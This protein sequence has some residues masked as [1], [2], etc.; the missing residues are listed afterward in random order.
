DG[1]ELAHSLFVVL[2]ARLPPTLTLISDAPDGSRANPLEPD[3]ETVG[4][5]AGP[6]GPVAIV[7]ERVNRPKAARL[8]LFSRETL[9][10]IGPLY[11]DIARRDARAWLPGF[12][13]K[14]HVGNVRLFEWVAILLALGVLYI[15][16]VLLNYVLTA[17]AVI[18]RRVFRRDTRDHVR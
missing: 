18:I 5:I 13:F 15:V 12:L 16:T 6:T 7:L 3:L 1:Q 4:T 10:E 8:W 14:W 2:D 17:L 11:E 9:D